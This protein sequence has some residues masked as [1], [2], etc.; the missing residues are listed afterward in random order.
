M[1]KN[2]AINL[3]PQEE[4]DASTTGRI[5]K[6]ATNTFRIIVIVT[7]MVVMAAFL[8][9]FWLDAQNST[10]NNA[11]RVKSAQISAQAN[12]EKQFRG[13]Q[14]KLDIFDKLSGDKKISDLVGKITSKVPA[15]VTLSGI[16]VGEGTINIRGLSSSD[17]DIGQFV[18]SLQGETF[19]SVELQQVGSSLTSPGGTDFVIAIT[20]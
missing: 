16:T 1:P 20:Y 7:E 18:V 12:L 3:L 13:V 19:K 11:I 8:S 4:F 15:S 9:R 10:L 17:F 2:K 14:T 5:L 6:W